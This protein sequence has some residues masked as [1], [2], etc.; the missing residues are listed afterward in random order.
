VYFTTIGLEVVIL[1]AG[2]NKSTQAIDIE[3]A[4][5]LARNLEK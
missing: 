2:G 4:L 1:L 3:T 5:K